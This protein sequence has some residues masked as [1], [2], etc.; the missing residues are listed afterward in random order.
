MP[1]VEAF[2][3]GANDG[4]YIT[5]RGALVYGANPNPSSNEDSRLGFDAHGPDERVSAR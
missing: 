5:A 2:G 1:V 3:F 4:R